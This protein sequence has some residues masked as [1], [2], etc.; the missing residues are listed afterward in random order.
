MLSEI[1]CI[2]R[3]NKHTKSIKSSQFLSYRLFNSGSLL[4]VSRKVA[5]QK[6]IN[7]T[8]FR[9]VLNDGVH[10]GQTVNQLYLQVLGG[11]Q[12]SWPFG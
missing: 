6:G 10:G 5:K 4:N 12:M 3:F 7:D 9:V 8:G 2:A 1:I 11:R